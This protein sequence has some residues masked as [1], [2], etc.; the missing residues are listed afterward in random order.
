MINPQD[1]IQVYSMKQKK[2]AVLKA[3]TITWQEFSPDNA[4]YFFASSV[5]M[6]VKFSVFYA[7]LF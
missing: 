2:W 3:V 6:E 7:F 1:I 4:P 5:R